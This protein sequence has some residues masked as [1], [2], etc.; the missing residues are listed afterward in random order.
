MKT[1]FTAKPTSPGGGSETI[2]SP[3]RRLVV[4][5]VNPLNL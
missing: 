3:D 5:V 4:T 2:Q 1:L